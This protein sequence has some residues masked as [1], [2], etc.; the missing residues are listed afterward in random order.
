ML[1]VC[2]ASASGTQVTLQECVVWLPASL[3]REAFE[4]QLASHGG[5]MFAEGVRFATLS[6][7]APL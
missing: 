3:S 5:S 7:G 6:A 4:K 1:A 2:N